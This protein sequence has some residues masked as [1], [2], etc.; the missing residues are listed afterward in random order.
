MSFPPHEA[1]LCGRGS[2]V[3]S[4]QCPLVMV[5][6]HLWLGAIRAIIRA[7]LQAALH[8]QSD[9]L[10]GAFAGTLMQMG[11]F[12]AS[13][14]AATCKGLAIPVAS[15]LPPTQLPACRCI[16][17]VL[18]GWMFILDAEQTFRRTAML[19][20]SCCLK[21]LLVGM[22]SFA[23]WTTLQS[24]GFSRI[25]VHL[26][27]TSNVK[28]LS[29][30]R[31]NQ[32]SRQLKATCSRSGRHQQT[33]GTIASISQCLCCFRLYVLHSDFSTIGHDMSLRQ[34]QHQYGEHLQPLVHAGR[35]QI[36]LLECVV[37]AI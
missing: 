18:G 10:A 26:S 28:V 36:S 32:P 11:R 34:G 16:W 12:E 33:I 15:L 31:D 21:G 8:S 30:L 14:A 25:V 37:P 1:I 6:D 23:P 19:L 5:R 35:G 2:L 20:C 3:W 22:V 29:L 17:L 7:V 27:H 13:F 24:S 9:R 4:R